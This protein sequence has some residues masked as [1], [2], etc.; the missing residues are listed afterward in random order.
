MEATQTL[1]SMTL[2][3]LTA[4]IISLRAQVQALQPKPAADTVEMT[5]DMARR[6]LNG[7]LRAKSHKEAAAALNLTYGQVYSCRGRYTFK[8][9]HKE[10]EADKSYSN[11]WAK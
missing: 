1:K 5:D 2:A 4:E 8:A 7:D 6:I 9:I 10:L 11:I 3:E